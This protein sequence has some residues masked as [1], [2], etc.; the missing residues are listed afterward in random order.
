MKTKKLL[1]ILLLTCIL[2]A[3]CA[4]ASTQTPIAEFNT[5]SSI[6]SPKESRQTVQEPIVKTGNDEGSASRIDQVAPATISPLPTQSYQSS[7]MS[8]ERRV[9]LFQ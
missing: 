4:P 8:P 2:L 7:G 6:E 3:A 9:A 1:S 5:N